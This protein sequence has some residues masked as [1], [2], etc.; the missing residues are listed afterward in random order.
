MNH[1][2][3]H[4]PFC[5]QKCLYCS[6]T[7]LT[8]HSKIETYLD[9]L[10]RE[11]DFSSKKYPKTKVK[12]IYIGGGTPGI[13]DP[14]QIS[15]IL[16]KLNL[17]FNICDGA[18]IT[19]E[20]NPE[21]ADKSKLLE[22][23]KAGINRISLGIQSFSDKNLQALGR[24]HTASKAVK[25]IKNVA[26]VFGNYNIDMIYALPN[27]C[28]YDLMED[29]NKALQFKPPHISCYELTYEEG[30]PLYKQL[31]KK[32]ESGRELY[33]FTQDVLAVSGYN[34]YE[35]S[36]YAKPGFEC[37]HNLAYWSNKSYLGV[38]LSA[39]SFDKDFKLR[40]GNTKDINA[41]LDG[42]LI[43]FS[44][45]AQDIDLMI[46]GLRKTSGIPIDEIPQ[47]YHETICKLINDGLLQ[48][49]THTVSYTQK[50]RILENQV[51]ME[52]LD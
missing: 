21:V 45:P 17:H 40:W 12:T 29:L 51:L 46:M 1:I 6:F 5:L 38:G 39:H 8:D 52:F 33:Y 31:D 47:G 9:A 23:R 50:G 34:Q 24:V 35:I 10:H 20:T 44:E 25:A 49:S 18:E 4:I 48:R 43:D 37:K 3:I 32:N 22:F 7:S 19:L 2:Y 15:I 42:D 11:I 28:E 13:L 16:D 26:S 30:T 27:Q 36:N 41:Y 14:K